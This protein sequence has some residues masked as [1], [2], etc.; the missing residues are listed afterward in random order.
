MDWYPLKA[1]LTYHNFLLVHKIHGK[2]YWR[3]LISLAWIPLFSAYPRS[4][5]YTDAWQFSPHDA[6]QN[7]SGLYQARTRTV[8]VGVAID[9]VDTACFDGS[10]RLPG[11][12][13]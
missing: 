11:G 8:D 10:Q 4:L 6:A 1:S 3:F 9:G 12:M 5:V 13:L 7:L 2:S